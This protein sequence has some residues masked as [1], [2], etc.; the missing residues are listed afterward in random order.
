MKERILQDLAKIGSGH[1]QEKSMQQL[2]TL[3]GLTP[4]ELT[5]R[6]KALRA[7]MLHRYGDMAVMTL[8]SFTN[9]LVKSFA[10]D[11]ALDQDYRIELD[12]DRIVDEA[13]A[14]LLDRVGLES[15]QELTDLL[16]GYARLQVEEDKDSRIRHPLTTHGKE[17]L[18][19]GMRDA[20]SALSGMTPKDFREISTSIR[21]EVHVQNK[22]LSNLAK[23]A[24]DVLHHEGITKHDVSRGLLYTW[25]DKN[26]RGDAI[27]PSP[28]LANMFDEGIFTT[29]KAEARI[30]EAVERARPSAEKVLQQV[31]LMTGETP[32]GR[33]YLLR[34]RL[35]HKIDL[36]GT[37]AVLS[38][39]I[40][41]VQ[42]TRNVR[43][44]QALHDR[45]ARVVRHNPVPF[46]YERMGVRFKHVFV[47]EFQDTSVIQ[48]QNLI[49]LVDNALAERNLSMV[50]GDGKQ[51]IY[52]WRNGDHRQLYHLPNIFDDPEGAFREA[53][54]TFRSTLGGPGDGHL[55]GDL[56]DRNYRSGQAIVQWNS[57]FFSTLQARLP[58]SIGKVYDGHHQDAE[59]DFEGQVHVRVVSDKDN[60]TRKA[61]LLDAILARVHHHASSD[62]GGF[63]WSDMAILVR[64]NKLGAEIAQHLLDKGVTPQTE[65]SLHVGRHPAALAVVAL[66][67]WVVEPHEDGHATSWLQCMAALDSIHV[68]ETKVLDK[69]VGFNM[70][71]NGETDRQFDAKSM[72][73]SLYPELN[74]L[75]QSR[76]PLV[77]WIGHACQTLGLLGR[78]DAYAEAMME[79]AQEVTGTEDGGLRG[80]L[81]AWDRHGHRRS[82]VASGGRDAVQ[83]MT[84]HKA[85]G[86]AFPVT[87][88]VASDNPSR[89]VKGARPVVLDDS[90][91]VDLPA[92]LL[93]VHDMKDTALELRAEEELDQALLDQINIMYVGM[94]RPIERLD[95]LAELKKLDFDRNAPSTVSQWV[96]ACTEEVTGITFEASGQCVERGKGDRPLQPRKSQTDYIVQTSSLEW[97]N[98]AAQSVR[99]APRGSAQ[100]HPD[101]LSE[102][103]KGILLH[104]LMAQVDCASD[105]PEIKQ[106]FQSQ[107]TLSDRDRE[108]VLSWAESVLEHE[109]SRRFFEDF[110]HV[111]SEAE[112]VDEAGVIR[113]DRVVFLEGTWHIIDYKTGS[114]DAHQTT[115]NMSQVRRYM[116]ALSQMEAAPVK[117]WLLHLNPWRLQEVA[118]NDTPLIFEAD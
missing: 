90:L 75:D 106:R 35:V 89:E 73:E 54:N 24:M 5:T 17:L 57:E 88:V 63:G 36:V 29:K 107:W 68:N 47:D 19:E 58:E 108:D 65:D 32:E 26:Q 43:T 92:A 69:H 15:E 41:R 80:F 1:A 110:D 77:S 76:G 8:D 14:N 71:E 60:E 100:V 22:L 56:M 10:R 109:A 78:F 72:I 49:P 114:D 44:F 28:T 4:D 117:G 7:A 94:T 101:G 118:A 67:R 74:A 97:K 105:W 31:R 104:D 112:W 51:A 23:E 113:P 85:K 64:T 53:Q 20:M 18:K 70:N 83:V 84:V 46:V 13:V 111:E 61:D 30:V 87:M 52:R 37:L 81:R 86:L 102:K 34:K 62:G 25:L 39:E 91:G 21:S 40:E 45:V 12:Q 99:L 82:I 33:A 50:V 2:C 55:G 103:E 9:R 66:T 16:K 27:A 116:R 59:K 115:K 3:T 95:V 98:P 93:N 42:Q 6:A 48:W 11:L 79:L 38:D 96:V